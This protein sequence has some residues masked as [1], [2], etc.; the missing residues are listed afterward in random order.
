MIGG[1][2]KDVRDGLCNDCVKKKKKFQVRVFFFLFKE[3]PTRKFT[4]SQRSLLD[5]TWVR[6]NKL[7]KLSKCVAHLHS[8]R[9]TP[10]TSCN[11][12]PDDAMSHCRCTHDIFLRSTLPQ[13][14][15]ACAREREITRGGS[16]WITL[17]QCYYF[18]WTSLTL[19]ISLK[20]RAV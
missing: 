15:C 10:S 18:R 7:R 2:L 13:C 6:T 16:E 12:K 3:F 4:V 14:A 20:C 19:F 1:V 5:R 17:C 9:A 8:R 11:A